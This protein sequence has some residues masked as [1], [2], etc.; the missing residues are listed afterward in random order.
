MFDFIRNHSRLVLGFLLLLV[1]PSFVVFGIEGY[2]RFAGPGRET[3]AKVGGQN[4]TRAEWEQA[5]ERVL[6][7]AR[8]GGGDAEQAK[9]EQARLDTLDALARERVLMAAA[10]DQH[11][12]P[13]DARLKRLFDADPQYRE[14]RGPDGKLSREMLAGIGLTP[15]L[16][17]QRLRQEYGMR[18][19]LMGV[20]MS[21]VM[22]SAAAK[23]S[24]EALFQRREVQVQR[25]AIA[26]YRAKITPGDAEIETYYKAHEDEFRSIEQAD[27][28]YVVFDQDVLAR[29]IAVE[30]KDARKF[31]EDNL[32]TRFTAPEERRASHILIQADA[33]DPKARA[34]AKARAEELLAQA[35][36]KPASFAELAKKHSQDTASASLGGDLEFA[37]RGSM[38][39]KPLEDAVFGMKVGEIA[40]PVESEFGYHVVTLTAQRGGQVRPFDEV[41]AEVLGELRKAGV[42][43]R[44]AGEAVEFTNMAYEQPDSLQ[45]LIDKFK[46]EKKTAT[47]Q[48][49]PVPGA[50]G[51]LASAKLLAGVF[52]T[53]AVKNKRNTDAVEFGPNQLVAARVLQHQPARVKPLAEVRELARERVIATQAAALAKKDGEARLAAVRAN[54][55][56]TLPETMVI[57]RQQP[58][59]LPLPVVEAAFRADP[60]KLPDVQGVDLGTA[61]FAVLRLAKVLPPDLPP[62]AD[63]MFEGQ[64]AQAFAGAETEAYLEALKRRYKLEVKPAARVAAAAA[65]AS[66]AGP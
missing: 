2:S 56:E 65:A 15:A 54:A 51:P 17:E 28:E 11:L 14:L 7:R 61:G 23:L 47:V 22:P 66:S 21:G 5:H 59:G 1:V 9:G 37:R 32:K 31:Y 53:D 18:Q 43:K 62:G 48:R 27:I 57:S 29:T 42:A 26:A 64:V 44:W 60:A 52:S 50:Q 39:A 24:I 10:E 3:V 16:L 49:T 41:K 36:A 19:V 35:R 33:A 12:Y 4:I 45:P 8:R 30:D 63:K 20:A 13:I 58:S 38:A 46:L 6:D 55:S 34:Q 40:G 25:F